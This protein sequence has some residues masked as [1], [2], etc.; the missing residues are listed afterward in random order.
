MALGQFP[1]VCR[2]QKGEDTLR[3]QR[4][5]LTLIYSDTWGKTQLTAGIRPKAEEILK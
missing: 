4:K 2:A 5:D 3:N 1:C